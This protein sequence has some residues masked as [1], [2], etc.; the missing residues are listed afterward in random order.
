MIS[1]PNMYA[2]NP[3]KVGGVWNVYLGG[4]FTQTTNG[5]IYFARTTNDTLAAGYHG[6]RAVVA[7]GV[8]QHVNDPST[9]K[10]KNRWVMA[11]TTA[12]A[13]GRQAL[14]PCLH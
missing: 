9:V 11:M 13:A 8:Y 2:P 4:W 7:H 14:S 1:G 3:V 6:V 10:V 12:T 5:E